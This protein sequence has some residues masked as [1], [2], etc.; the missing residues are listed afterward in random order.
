[1]EITQEL[2]K[3]LFYYKDGFL[4]WKERPKWSSI[5]IREPAGCI[6][7]QPYCD[8]RIVQIY[9]K[10]YKHYRLVFLFHKGYLPKIVDHKDLNA[11]N[12]SIE[13]LRE[14]TTTQNQTNRPSAI[15]SSSQYLGV[16][17]TKKVGVWQVSIR[18]MRKKIYLGLYKSEIDAAI[19]YD[20]AAKIHHGEFANLNFKL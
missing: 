5:D 14:A 20:N 7:K 15:N 19:A 11:L 13:N 12:D 6:S 3:Q 4:Y 16:S 17:R 8:R 9:R 1:M 10:Q 18:V 2:L